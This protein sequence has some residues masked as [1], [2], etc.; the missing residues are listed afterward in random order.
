MPNIV[1][2]LVTASLAIPATS[3]PEIR[4]GGDAQEIHTT[5]R[6]LIY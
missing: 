4:R 1:P 6:T 5:D 2:T 3:G